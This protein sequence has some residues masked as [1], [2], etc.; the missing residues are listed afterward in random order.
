MWNNY[1]RILSNY[2]FIEDFRK[3]KLNKYI[4]ILGEENIQIIKKNKKPVVFVSGHFNNFELMALLLEKSE[5]ELAAIYR[6]LN[7][8]FLNKKMEKIRKNYICKNQIP[9][10]MPGIRKIIELLD[11]LRGTFLNLFLE[12]CPFFLNVRQQIEKSYIYV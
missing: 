7:N 12:I 2:V 9:K 11:L 10:G 6:P 8:L 3:S 4:K 1:G 5:I